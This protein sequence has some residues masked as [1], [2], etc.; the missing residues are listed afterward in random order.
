METKT[1]QFIKRTNAQTASFHYE[2]SCCSFLPT[3]FVFYIS[4]ICFDIVFFFY[5]RL[6]VFFFLRCCTVFLFVKLIHK[7]EKHKCPRST[8]LI[9]RFS[10]R[11][12]L[13]EF[14]I[15]NGKRQRNQKVW[16]LSEIR[17][18]MWQRWTGSGSFSRVERET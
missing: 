1:E 13:S 4:S 3:I 6:Y 16:N 5:F 11:C 18:H 7:K 2:P 12:R 17:P 14:R 10:Q 9:F 15:E 8:V